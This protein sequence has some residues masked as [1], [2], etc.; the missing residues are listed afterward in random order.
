MRQV[1][2]IGIN[3]LVIKISN[4]YTFK[5]KKIKKVRTKSVTSKAKSQPIQVILLDFF[6]I[7]NNILKSDN[8]PRDARL[9]V[10]LINKFGS[11]LVIYFVL[12]FKYSSMPHRNFLGFYAFINNKKGGECYNDKCLNT[13][14]KAEKIHD[15]LFP[16]KETQK[17]VNGLISEFTKKF[18]KG[19]NNV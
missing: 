19:E 5:K 11:E 15:R 8:F 17:D 13:L 18:N 1:N 12:R 6:Y 2:T 16:V 14:N 4:K 9:M 10:R 7:S 3:K